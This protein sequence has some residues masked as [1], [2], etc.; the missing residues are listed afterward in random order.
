MCFHYRAKMMDFQEA[1]KRLFGHNPNS[2]YRVVYFMNDRGLAPG[3]EFL[4]ELPMKVQVKIDRVLEAVRTAPP[5]KFSGGGYWE[6]MKGD[7]KGFYEVRVDEGGT[8][9]HH[10]LF[11]L[12]DRDLGESADGLIVVLDGDSKKRGTVLSSQRY[13]EIQAL[14]D[15]YRSAPEKHRF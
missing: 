14:G 3:K 15:L 12:L 2:P 9:V 5:P 10:R 11:C 4:D 7:L 8:R 1:S 6:A 13:A